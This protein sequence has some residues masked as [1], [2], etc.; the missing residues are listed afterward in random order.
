DLGYVIAP[1]Q[2]NCSGIEVQMARYGPVY[3]REAYG[4]EGGS[5]TLFEYELV[6]TL[7]QTVGNDPEGL[8]IPQEGGGVYGRNVADYLGTDKEKYRWHFLIK[9]RRDMDDYDP[10]MDLTRALSLGQSAFAATI[11]QT[12]DVDQWLQSFA[13]GCTISAGDN[14]ISDSAH[15]AMFYFRPTDGRFTFF[16]HDMDYAY[17][18]NRSLESNRVL[19][20]LLQTPT[21]AHAF[22]GYVYDF[23][24]VSFNG[25]YMSTW[26]DH[27]EQLLP[28]QSW[29]SWLS[30]INGRSQNVMNQVLATAGPHV[31]FEITTPSDAVVTSQAAPIAGRGWIDVHEICLVE[32]GQTLAAEWSDLTTWEAHLPADLAP[33]PYTLGAYDNQGDLRATDTI[34]LMS[35][36]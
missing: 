36:Q 9:N 4:D 31:P 10:V 29:S 8:K 2:Q 34:I 18:Q 12:I 35:G 1:R 7:A 25:A 17:Q 27:Y 21:W 19:R 30:Y 28:E 15:N 32:T 5:G 16:L 6:Y 14:W 11:S 3:C 33:G 26:A 24:Q 13:V 20:R 22:Y 23:V